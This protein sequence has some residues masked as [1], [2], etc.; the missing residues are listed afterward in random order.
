M[1]FR[2]E[3]WQLVF[4][5]SGTR[6][7]ASRRGPVHTRQGITRS[8]DV[9]HSAATARPPYFSASVRRRKLPPPASGGMCF[10]RPGRPNLWCVLGFPFWI[11][12]RPPYFSVNTSS[13]ID[14]EPLSCAGLELLALAFFLATRRCMNFG[15]FLFESL[16]SGRVPPP[17]TYPL[18]EIRAPEVT[19]V[20]Q[21]GLLL[22]S[23]VL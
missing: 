20:A 12:K 1:L 7:K 13:I 5:L 15:T 4:L 22:H 14:G 2:P 8:R 18:R 21:Q 16:R 3:N 10:P 17:S 9:H 23:P 6:G 11:P 19:H